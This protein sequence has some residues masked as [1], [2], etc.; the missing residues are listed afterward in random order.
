MTMKVIER[1]DGTQT[2]CRELTDPGY[3]QMCEAD[4]HGR[5]KPK[6][7]DFPIITGAY[8]ITAIGDGYFSVINYCPF[9]DCET[10]WFT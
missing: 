6:M 4:T 2:I 10:T 7:E 3:G 9:T 8:R 1:E 5:P